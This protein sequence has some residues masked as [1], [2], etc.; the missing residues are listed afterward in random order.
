MINIEEIKFSPT[1]SIWKT[2]FDTTHIDVVV[3]ISKSIIKNQ[4]NVTNDGYVYYI[5]QNLKCSGFVDLPINDE[6]DKI[7]NYAMDSC[8]AL[9]NSNFNEIKTDM[10]VNMVRV[11]NPVQKNT[12]SNGELVFHNHVD[13]NIINKRAPPN[14]TFVCYIQMP[15]NLDDK[16]G[17]LFLQDIDKS[18]Y[19]ILPE[20]GDILIMDGGLPHVPNY[21]P[22]STKDRIVL[23]GNMRMDLSK[24]KSSLI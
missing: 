13:L 21:A 14:Y 20:V 11:E 16:D 15:D 17:V 3:D 2:K 7:R 12:K 18:V 4:P 19:D 23:A 9:F 1:L 22:N 10:W 24:L 6:L 5:N 8:I